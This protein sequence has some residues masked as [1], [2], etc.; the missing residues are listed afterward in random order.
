M[1]DP[2]NPEVAVF[3]A[4]LE[5]PAD[6]R[7]AYLDKA[8]AGNADLRL[9]VEALLKVH[10]DAGDFFDKLAPESRPTTA[11]STIPSE[12]IGDRI[13]RYKLL[14]QIGEGG[15]GV[16]YMAEQEEPVRRKIALKVIK[17]GMDTK[18]VIARFEAE[19]QALAL[20]D[21]PNIAKVLDA[22]ATDTGRPYFVMELVRGI[23]IT[24]YCD[25]NNLSTAARLGLFVQ[26]CQAIQHAHQKGI[27]HRDIKP[28][29]IMVAD[30]DGVPVPKII[31]FGIAK[32]TTDQRL[33]D[34]TVFTALEQFLGTPAY[35]SPEQ[36]KLSGL[37]IDTRSDIYS[38]GVLLYE[39]LTGKTP[40]EAKRLLEA[41]LDEVRRIIREE[42][43]VTPST[44]LQTLGA[45]EQTTL[46]KF[47]Q[48]EPPKL[49]HLIRGD[50]DWIVMKCLEKDRGRRYE[51]AN[52]LA[53]DLQ[54]HLENEPVLARSPSAG[55]RLQKAWRRHRAVFAVATLIAVVL[56]VATGVSTWQAIR[57]SHEADRAIKAESL[58]TQRLADAEAI[59]KFLAE[60][61]K[62]PSPLRDGRT[63]TVAET[64][65]NA[66]QKLGTDLANQPARLAKLQSAIGEAYYGLGL[67]HEALPLQEKVRDYYLTA[68]G[69]ENPDT[70]VAT[71]RV[72]TLYASV[73]RRDEALKLF[74]QVLTL[75]RKMLGPEHPD[76][77]SAMSFL[78]TSYD[79][80]GRREDA[81]KLRE[82]VLTLSRK[83]NGP[84]HPITIA[85]MQDVASS[86]IEV[87]RLNESIALGE[88]A[89][90]LNTK[91]IG[92]QNVQTL[93]S[94]DGLAGSYYAAGRRDEALKLWE[95]ALPLERKVNGPEHPSTLKTMNNLS[96]GYEDAGRWD[97][98]L[99]LREQALALYRKINGP[100]HPDTLVAMQS[101]AISYDQAGRHDEAIKLLEETVELSRKSLGAEHPSTISA[102]GTLTVVLHRAGRRDEA[103]KLAEEVLAL[104]LKV[105]GPENHETLWAMRN[106]AIFY[107]DAGRLDE[108]IKL[109]EQSVA[110]SRKALGPAH[111]DTIGA[112]ST[113][114]QFYEDAGRL[115][116]FRKLWEQTVALD[117]EAYGA[118]DPA[119]LGAQN[120][121][122]WFQATGYAAQLR[123]GTNAVRL[124][125]EV[126]A[127]THRKDGGFLDTLAASYAETQQFD[128][129]A[130]VQLEAIALLQNEQDK[131][132]CELRLKLYQAHKPFHASRAT[133]ELRIQ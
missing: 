13:G 45:A 90:A 5:L 77:I 108:S 84:E 103:I 46:A 93:A 126:V 76:T 110:L 8:C 47:R 9:Q 125:E 31:D 2:P 16:V 51:T 33:T 56:L 42:E 61:F 102:M 59:S 89:L 36:A 18:S 111:P 83:L 123:N 120:Y 37:D 39:L 127:A 87:G 73:G 99:K 22:G 88:Q 55:Y 79:Q 133:N 117:R 63:I 54:R 48:T 105:L 82:E 24:N 96:A 107:E 119:R 60:V 15:C 1:S 81:L 12:K 101:M 65:S 94:M 132:D 43:P 67:S 95:E 100:G 128:K 32:A 27:I 40:F 129:A 25:E 109:G 66:T 38:L 69:P 114:A 86:Y 23:K 91:V 64:L 58:A 52:G 7:S 14:Q 80:A 68:F 34:K 4:A 41:G 131:K 85:T 26:V 116:D 71:R 75:S 44:R 98:A 11:E 72:A 124:A 118:Q 74:E 30:H 35:M 70:I 6:Q 78:A 122:A 115:D 97:D 28:S 53:M 62:S 130:A 104:K 49:V 3:A 57:A 29:N 106:L 113:L 121:L 17:L 112:T 92:P 21:H 10:D 50:L 19:R 20:M